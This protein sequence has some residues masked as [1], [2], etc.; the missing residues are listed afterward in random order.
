[1]INYLSVKFKV[2]SLSVSFYFY[3]LFYIMATA[4]FMFSDDDTDKVKV[5]DKIGKN[6]GT[7]LKTLIAKRK[8]KRGTATRNVNLI[9]N[10]LSTMSADQCKSQLG[11]LKQLREDLDELD[12]K[13]ICAALEGNVYTDTEMD[14]QVEFNEMYSHKISSAIIAVESALKATGSDPIQSP[15]AATKTKLPNVELPVFSGSLMNLKGLLL[16]LSRS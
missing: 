14:A 13:V 4:S 12:S 6:L 5:M 16:L 9:H 8:G 1:M 2:V 7:D 11:I 15:L 3:L 10:R